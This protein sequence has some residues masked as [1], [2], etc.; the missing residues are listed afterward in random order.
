LDPSTL[1]NYECSG[2]RQSYLIR[3]E[4]EGR[5]FQLHV[6]FGHRA[7][8]AVRGRMLAI[9]SSLKVD[10]CPPTVD[11]TRLRAVLTPTRGPVGTPVTLSA[12]TGRDE[13]GFWSPLT[14]IEVWW[15]VGALGAPVEG[16]QRQLVATI[17][18]GVECSF[19]ATFRVPATQLGTYVITVIDYDAGGFGYW[20]G[21]TF[22]VTS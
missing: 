21:Q 18:P 19:D 14:K 7:S 9:L 6:A 13:D 15:S 17:D 22:V 8:P 1:A 16:H 4:D 12:P 5:T 2:S 10:R 11:L 3:F 20:P